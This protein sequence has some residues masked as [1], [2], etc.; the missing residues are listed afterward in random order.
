LIGQSDAVAEVT[1]DFVLEMPPELTALG[2]QLGADSTFL[3]ERYPAKQ[4]AT[5]GAAVEGAVNAGR[6][7]GIG[8]RFGA[9]AAAVL[10]GVLGWQLGSTQH[11]AINSRAEIPASHRMVTNPD[12]AIAP[13]AAI[14]HSAANASELHGDQ[15]P[16]EVGVDAPSH[17]KHSPA[18]EV[19]MLRT[20]LN[21]FEKVI[22]IL[23]TE[24]AARKQAEA[25]NRKLIESLQ[26][27]IAQ[28]KSESK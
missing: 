1:D 21:G 14:V 26:A 24:L 20:Q 12:L 13:H 22:G 2:E 28:L 6:R 3:A 17:A 18:D 7:R 16:Q 8:F 11:P 25:E 10:A 4:S 15:S 9:A 5:I 19:T 23:Q 27:E